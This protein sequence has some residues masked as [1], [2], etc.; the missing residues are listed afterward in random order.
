MLAA[1]PDKTSGTL[2]LEQA[3]VNW[4][5]S[6]DEN[7][8]AC[9][10]PGKQDNALSVPWRLTAKPLTSVKA[11]IELHTKAYEAILPGNGIPLEETRK[12]IQLV[13]DIRKV[14]SF[15]V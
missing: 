8:L 12:G 10:P 11:S 7:D 14:Q 1:A 9:N 4:K 15:A 13:H 2:E 6:I 5:L 3:K